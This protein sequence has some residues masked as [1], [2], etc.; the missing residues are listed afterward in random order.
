MSKT[1]KPIDDTALKSML[2]H[3]DYIGAKKLIGSFLDQKLSAEEK[4]KIYTQVVTTY[5]TMI[6]DVNKSYL[7]ELVATNQALKKLQVSEK[8]TNEKLRISEL[9]KQLSE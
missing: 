3:S 7:E 8:D 9:K 5:L 1:P 6:N 2:N 4:G